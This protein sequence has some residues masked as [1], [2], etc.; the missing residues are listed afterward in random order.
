MPGPEWLFTLH[1]QGL[2]PWNPAWAWQ[3]FP[4][5][6]VEILCRTSGVSYQ[7]VN[8]LPWGQAYVPC[9]LCPEGTEVVG[10]INVWCI[11]KQVCSFPFSRR[12]LKLVEVKLFVRGHTASKGQTQELGTSWDGLHCPFPCEGHAAFMLPGT[13]G[14]PTGSSTVWQSAD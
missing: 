6:V 9:L 13:P 7:L 1:H 2:L 14:I 3:Q 4:P 5:F 10:I 8:F 11:F 12:R